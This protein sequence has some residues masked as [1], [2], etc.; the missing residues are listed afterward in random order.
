M[1]G[2]EDLMTKGGAL[3]KDSACV[4]SSSYSKMMSLELLSIAR[5]R[6]ATKENFRDDNSIPIT[7]S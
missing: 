6:V 2:I 1:R 3:M 7:H 4:R 5:V